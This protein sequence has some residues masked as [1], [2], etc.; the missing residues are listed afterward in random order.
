MQYMEV[1]VDSRGKFEEK[2]IWVHIEII[3]RRLDC[4]LS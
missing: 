3:H 2:N 4:R 1:Y